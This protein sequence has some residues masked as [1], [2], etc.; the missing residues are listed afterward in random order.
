MAEHSDGEVEAVSSWETF[1]A[2]PDMIDPN[3]L[4]TQMSL[5]ACL[6][7]CVDIDTDRQVEEEVMQ[8]TSASRSAYHDTDFQTEGQIS[9]L[10]SAFLDA[11]CNTDDRGEVS[12]SQLSLTS[13][14]V[15]LQSDQL[16]GGEGSHL[17]HFSS[18]MEGRSTDKQIAG[19][20]D[21][22]ME[23]LLKMSEIVK[24]GALRYH[25]DFLTKMFLTLIAVFYLPNY[26][27]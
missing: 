14:P 27:C 19:M 12:T 15:C 20:V 26:V 13:D 24:H 6:V 5:S 9:Q 11:D 23:W 7:D 18:S 1:P 25:F 3:S 22:M 10:S 17:L 21:M 16:I 4:M 2:D 8:S